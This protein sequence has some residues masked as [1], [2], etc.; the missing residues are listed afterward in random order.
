MPPSTLLMATFGV[1]TALSVEH[2]RPQA[3]N[4]QQKGRLKVQKWVSRAFRVFWV[5][6]MVQVFRVTVWGFRGWLKGLILGLAG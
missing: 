2:C 4:V 1:S 5:F 3:G 6:R